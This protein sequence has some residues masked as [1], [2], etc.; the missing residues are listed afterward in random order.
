MAR[1][2][3]PIHPDLRGVAKK[4]P[5][6]PINRWTVDCDLV[7]VEGAFHGFD[8]FMDGVPVCR[9]FLRGRW[10]G[11]GGIWWAISS[12]AP[13]HCIVGTPRFSDRGILDKHPCRTSS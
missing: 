4:F 13:A 1:D 8:A 3:T 5:R 11:W 9:D 2:L 12:L 10:R 6:L 7:V